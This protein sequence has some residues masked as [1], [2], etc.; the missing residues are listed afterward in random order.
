MKRRHKLKKKV[1][2]IFVF[3]S[4]MFI[5]SIS[6]FSVLAKVVSLKEEKK[7]LNNQ[8]TLKEEEKLYLE[9]EMEKLKNE[10]YIARYAREK[11]LF[12]KEGEFI[13]KIQK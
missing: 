2:R 12:S 9:S 8:L 6:V 1:V 13:I 4:L 11:Y 7:I 5:M 3:S 10:E